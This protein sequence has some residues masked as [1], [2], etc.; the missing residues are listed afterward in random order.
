MGAYFPSLGWF[1]KCS[2]T[3]AIPFLF[4]E[5]SVIVPGMM[6]TDLLRQLGGYDVQQ[7]YN[8]EDWELGIR[9]LR[10]DGQLSIFLAISSGIATGRIP[11]TAMTNVQNQVMRELLFGKHRETVSRFAVE[12]SMQ[13]EDGC[14]AFFSP[15]NS[16]KPARRISS[17]L[18][19]QHSTGSLKPTRRMSSL[20][21]HHRST[22][23]HPPGGSARFC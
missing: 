13:I 11:C 8:Y 4:A 2:S 14:T 16:L 9:M 6:P 22:G 5:N 17:L 3:G 7:R 19:H 15:T 12:I 1:W 21:P 10:P 23:S 20:L 18:P